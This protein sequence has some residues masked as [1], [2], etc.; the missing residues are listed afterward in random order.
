MTEVTIYDPATTHEAP[1]GSLVRDPFPNNIIPKAHMDP[2]ALKV[3]AL[4]PLPTGPC[5]VN[6]GLYP[7]P[8]Q[9]LTNIPA[10][11]LDHNLSSKA[12]LSY[13]WSQTTTAS[14][15]SI[16]LGGADGLPEPV[17]GAIGTFITARVQRL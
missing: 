6:N 7:F 10:I 17:T 15:Y 1:N 9:R 5:L 3:Q 11:K 14:Q 8:S 4:I 12:K 13:Y 2:V 16:P